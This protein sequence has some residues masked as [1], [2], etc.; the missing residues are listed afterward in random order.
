MSSF[1]ILYPHYLLEGNKESMPT[2]LTGFDAE[3]VVA[4]SLQSRFKSNTTT[5]FSHFE[6]NLLPLEAHEKSPDYIY[7]AGIDLTSRRSASDLTLGLFGYNDDSFTTV[8]DSVEASGINEGILMGKSGSDYIVETGSI[9]PCDYWRARI[10]NGGD[11]TTFEFRKVFFGRWF[12]FG[13]EP[14]VPFNTSIS[15]QDRNNRQ[16]RR[17]ISIT[18]DGISNNKIE[19]FKKKI[20]KRAQMPICLYDREKGT[21][22]SG[23]TVFYCKLVSHEVVRKI[24]NVNSI[25]CQFKEVI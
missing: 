10:A 2:S 23:E 24:H 25:T 8:V 18:W 20:A 16:Y 5:N 21:R 7:V 11:A 22:L 19:S 15:E 6:V 12:D 3:N 9:A 13:Y 14:S 4:G 17:T 1:V